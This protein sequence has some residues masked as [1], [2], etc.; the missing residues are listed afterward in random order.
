MKLP[1]FLKQV[2]TALLYADDGELLY[3]I[4]EMYFGDVKQNPI[5][6]I[7]GQYVS[8]MGILDWALVSKNGT[9]SPAKPFKFPTIFMCKPSSIEKVKNFRINGLEGKDYRILHFK[10]GD[11]VVS[12]INIPKI[13]DNVEILFRLSVITGDK[14][15][16]TVPY[17]K[18]HEYFTDS[19]HLNGNSYHLNMQMFGI[20]VSELCRNPKN[21]A[22]PFRYTKMDK[23]TGYR[24][25]AV[26]N[27]PK[28]ISPYVALTSV[29]FDEALMSSVVLSK[30]PD[31]KIKSTPLEKVITG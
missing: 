18:L 22:E 5:A 8:T 13:I 20:M 17:D 14:I 29:N 31:S 1:S 19:M 30:E 3:Y 9:V 6:Q 25:I 10:E 21:L 16:P 27:I 4:P 12:D 11:E 26:S 24:Q 23:M 15:P 28:Y 7:V 2:G